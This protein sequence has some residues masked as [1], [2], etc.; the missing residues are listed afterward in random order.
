M[1]LA[2]VDV[3][4]ASK[5]MGHADITTTLNIYTHL[6]EEYGKNDIS[7]MDKYLGSSQVRQ[8]TKNK[9]PIRLNK[10]LG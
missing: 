8:T 3:L 7:K 4:V 10:G 1:Y 5:Q 6:D 9:T 2:G